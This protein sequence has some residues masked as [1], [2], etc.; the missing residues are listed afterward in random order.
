[1]SKQVIIS[2]NAPAPAGPYNQ[3]IKAG[4]F[5]FVSGQLP[6]DFKTNQLRV[7]SIEEEIRTVFENVEAILK[8]AGMSFTNVVKA[9]IYLSDMNLFDEVN[10][11]FAQ[12]F[13]HEPP[14]RECVAVKTIPRNVHV[15]IS[16]IAYAE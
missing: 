13:T 5:L 2:K 11:V 1:M 6:V 10:K 7:G 14:A 15:E 8:E 12:Y 16:V 9:T 4:N 3:A